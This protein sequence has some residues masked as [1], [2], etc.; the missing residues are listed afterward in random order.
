MILDTSFIID[1]L[2]GDSDATDL[3]DIVERESK[4][5]KVS[6]ITLLELYEGVVRS[7]T[8]NQK[9]ER[10]LDVLETKSVVDADRAVMRK[11]GK[12]SGEL[13]LRGERIDREDC[14]VAATALLSDEPVVTRNVR[15]FERVDGLELRSY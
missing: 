2:R 11:A 3:L 4:P 8:P 13:V 14:I 12:I 15:H 10:I 1:L 5:L 9:A 7:E 6:S